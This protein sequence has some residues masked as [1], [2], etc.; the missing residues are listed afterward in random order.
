LWSGNIGKIESRDHLDS[1]FEMPAIT[2]LRKI[3]HHQIATMTMSD[4]FIDIETAPQFSS[5]EYFTVKKAIESGRLT[6]QSEN[7]D[8]YWKFERGG[9]TPFDGKIIL[10]TYK[11]NNGYVVRLKEWEIGERELLKKFY[12]LV[13]DLQKGKI[14]DHLRIIGHNILGFDLFFIYQR[15]RHHSIQEEKWLYQWVINKPEVIDFLQMHL[16]LNGY[17]T[18]GLKHDVLAHAYGFPVKSTLGSG[19]IPHYF[20]GDYEKII[21]YSQREFIYP[22]LYEK[23]RS[24]GLVSKERLQESIKHYENMSLSQGH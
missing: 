10:L 15:M 1:F 11:I 4:L 3:N 20:E 7:R 23:I 21:E 9:L 2:I 22:E 16:P 18:K 5:E 24:D 19:E 12:D 6:K 14:D 8:L 13:Y 17:K